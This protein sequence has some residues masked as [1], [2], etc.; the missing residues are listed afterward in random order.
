MW[1]RLSE[2]ERKTTASIILFPGILSRHQRSSSWPKPSYRMNGNQQKGK[3]NDFSKLLFGSFQEI[4]IFCSIHIKEINNCYRCTMKKEIW[5]DINV[6]IKVKFS[7]KPTFSCL[8]IEKTCMS[9]SKH[10]HCFFNPLK[11]E[12][13]E[14][15]QSN[16]FFPETWYCKLAWEKHWKNLQLS[17]NHT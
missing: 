5:H 8:Y 9:F 4:A 14:Y 6:F 2:H 17:N 11:S 12:G 15:A 16:F 10:E 1:V 13:N 3:L 7:S